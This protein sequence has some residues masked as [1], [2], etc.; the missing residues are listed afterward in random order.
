[1]RSKKRWYPETA[2]IAGDDNLF[3]GLDS[4]L[5][6]QFAGVRNLL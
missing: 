3:V 5:W 6:A 4:S 2:K 1:M